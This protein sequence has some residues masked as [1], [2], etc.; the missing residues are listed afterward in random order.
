MVTV[1]AY[2]GPPSRSGK[3]TKNQ[4]WGIPW[5][6]L[7]GASDCILGGDMQP[8][9]MSTLTSYTLG[10]PPL[11]GCNRH[12]QDYYVF[13]RG[14]TVNLHLPRGDN[15]GYTWNPFG[16]LFWNPLD[17]LEKQSLLFHQNKGAPFGFVVIW[18]GGFRFPTTL[19][20]IS[21][22]T[23]PDWRKQTPHKK[24]NE[25]RFNPQKI[26]WIFWI[27]FPFPK[28]QKKKSFQVPAP[29]V[30]KDFFEGNFPQL[31]LVGGFNPFEKY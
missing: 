2:G 18:G 14:S 12:H 10:C 9:N 8:I 4:D 20:E 5:F 13:S 7:E 15:P 26:C 3:K 22:K 23:N 16:L 30:F 6:R 28:G 1:G 21:L 17:P 24:R 19:S 29:L 27:F 11:P 31:L 25:R